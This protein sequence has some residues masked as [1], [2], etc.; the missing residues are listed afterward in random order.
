MIEYRVGKRTPALPVVGVH[1]VFLAKE[2]ILFLKEWILYHRLK[3]IEHF[4]LY[5]NTGSRRAAPVDENNPHLLHERVNKYGVPYHEIVC[6]SDTEI[7]E[8]LNEIQLEI[9]N[10]EVVKW[11]PRDEDGNIMYAQTQALNDALDHYGE[12]VD[13]MA[14]M[15]MDEYLV[16]DKTV[17]EL[18]RWLESR[19]YGGYDGG[20]MADRVMSTRLDNMDR[21]VT[22]NNMGFASPLPIA[23]KYLCNTRYVRHGNVHSFRSRGRQHRFEPQRAFFLHYKM[24]RRHP[25]MRERFEEVE[26]GINPDLIDSVKAAAGE[27]CT[28]EWRLSAVQPDW[29]RMME[30]VYPWWHLDRGG[31]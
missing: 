20:L 8:I 5:D 15:D 23:P 4:F 1:T 29:R 16:S 2:N 3:G 21:Y 24:P 30:E 14:F 12:M 22:E 26:T 9:P 19:G 6:L 7:Q 31:A 13:W 18:C 11:Q 25:E 10:V 28:P 17:P 27:N